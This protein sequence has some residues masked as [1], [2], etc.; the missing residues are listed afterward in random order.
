MDAA[1]PYNHCVAGIETA[2]GML[3]AVGAMWRDGMPPSEDTELKARAFHALHE[4]AVAA[5]GVL[6]PSALARLAV[7]HARDLLGVDAA[8][9]FGWDADASVLRWLAHNDPHRS[10]DGPIIRPGEG[11]TGLAFEQRAPVIVEN[12]PTWEHALS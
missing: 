2:R 7:N 6:D 10:D 4:M 12:Y 1:E 9:V 11:A 5:A 3:G 8:S